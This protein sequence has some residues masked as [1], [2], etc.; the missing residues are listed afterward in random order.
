MLGARDA[1]GLE[2]VSKPYTLADYQGLRR[3]TTSEIL[4]ND[5]RSI[6]LKAYSHGSKVTRLGLIDVPHLDSLVQAL[7]GSRVLVSLHTLAT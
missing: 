5:A 2:C 4:T 3:M 6:V 1:R 7:W